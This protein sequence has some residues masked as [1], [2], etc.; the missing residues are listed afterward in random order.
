M[1]ESILVEDVLV[2]EWNPTAKQKQFIRIPFDVKEALYGG[3]AG[4]GKSELL[5]LLPL[6]YKFYEHPFFKGL[7]MRRTF[8]ELEAEII[9]RSKEWYPSSGGI[10]NESKREWNWRS[11]ASIK[12]GHA[13]REEDVRKYDSAQYN[14]FGPDE[15]TS[16]TEF[17]YSFLAFSRVRSR[18]ADLPSIIRAAT[19]PGNIGHAFFRDRFVE[20]FREGGRIIKDKRTGLLRMFIQATIRD[21]PHLIAANPEYIQQL[22]SLP[23]AERRAKLHGD[24]YTFTG[25]VFNEFRLEPLADEPDNARHVIYPIDIPD[26][27]P[28]VVG[29]DWGHKAMTW[30]GWGAVAP[31]GQVIIYREYA[32]KG[33]LTTS[34]I[35][36]FIRL[37]QGEEKQIETI[38]IC[39]SANQNRGEPLT[40][41]K[42][43]ANACKENDFIAT[44]GLGSKGRINKKLNL[45]EYLRWTPRQNLVREYSEEFNVDKANT[46]FRNHGTAAYQMYLEMFADPKPED[47]LPKLQIFNTCEAVIKAI[48]ECIYE[49]SGTNGKN[50]E[51]VKE[52][53]GDDPY[54][55]ICILLDAVK[56][57]T[58]THSVELQERKEQQDAIVKLATSGDQTAYYRQMENHER[59]SSAEYGV[60]RSR[61]RRRR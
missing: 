26:W 45:H 35:D 59:R 42:Q 36:D 18:S 57:Y 37:S 44:V 20:P 3:A 1:S 23:E 8:P 15:A 25:Q 21:N 5:I 4:S 55:G 14:Y 28:R 7:I 43:L 2:K 16:F 46:I 6:I 51:D 34:W 41:I 32:E 58:V 10:Y 19:N 38:R 17:Q 27:W 50:S 22:E 56:D 61:H 29:I 12:F 54:D 52:F 53:E 49:S 31:N 47:N 39:H 33:K 60:R 13:D 40:I 48:P 11:G 9:K 30:I 24:W